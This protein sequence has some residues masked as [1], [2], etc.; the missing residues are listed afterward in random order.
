[1]SYRVSDQQHDLQRNSM[2]KWR[3]IPLSGQRTPT[4]SEAEGLTAVPVVF[5]ALCAVAIL[6]LT[7]NIFLYVY[8]TGPRVLAQGHTPTL[9]TPTTMPTTIAEAATATTVPTATGTVVQSTASPIAAPLPAVLATFVGADMT[10]EGSWS[11]IYGSQGYVLA[12]NNSQFPHSQI[13]GYASVNI[14]ADTVIW[15]S[16]TND[17]RALQKPGDSGNAKRIAAAWYSTSALT[18]DLD[19]TDGQ[20]HRIAFYL[21]DWDSCVEPNG[22]MERVDTQDTTTGGILDSH[23]LG[24]PSG[25]TDPADR[26]NHGKYLI[27]N[28]QRHVRFMIT[29]LNSTAVLSGVFFA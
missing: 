1:L 23:T 25:D 7:V 12:P 6:A 5:A 27:W 3:R 19:L 8:F 24:Q 13:P 26:F 21:L 4:Q 16:S 20:T 28:V 2:S 15:A 29:N 17:S 11:V 14:S 18:I 9:S 22:R 10:T